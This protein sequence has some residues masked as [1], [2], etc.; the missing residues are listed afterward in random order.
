[1]TDYYLR[2]STDGGK[3]TRELK[4]NAATMNYINKLS[5]AAPVR[6]YFDNGEWY[7]LECNVPTG[8]RGMNDAGIRAKKMA[9]EDTSGLLVITNKDRASLDGYIRFPE[10]APCWREDSRSRSA[11]STRPGSLEP[12]TDGLHYFSIRG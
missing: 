1:M 12:L 2:I 4:N 11:K 6:I 8:S 3:T 7:E 9:T 10:S 5:F